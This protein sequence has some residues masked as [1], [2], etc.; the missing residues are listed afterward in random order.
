ME[1]RAYFHAIFSEE[2]VVFFEVDAAP[3][4]VIDIVT[5]AKMPT[6]VLS[7]KTSAI[8]AMVAPRLGFPA[9]WS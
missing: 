3:N 7:R 9:N 1:R 4:H 6:Y 5:G 2:G 8:I